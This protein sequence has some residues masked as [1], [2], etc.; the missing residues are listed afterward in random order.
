MT[1]KVNIFQRKQKKTKEN[2]RKFVSLPLNKNRGQVCPFRAFFMPAQII[3]IGVY[4]RVYAVMASQTTSIVYSAG[5]Y[6]LFNFNIMNKNRESQSQTITGQNENGLTAENSTVK[7]K[8]CTMNETT[9]KQAEHGYTVSRETAN[10]LDCILSLPDCPAEIQSILTFL[11]ES[12]LP[13]IIMVNVVNNN[14]YIG[15]ITQSTVNGCN[16]L[17]DYNTL[18][19]AIITG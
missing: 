3:K 9:I 13:V 10:F 7:V 19:K 12:R 4:S 17:G 5:R 16:L 2:K 6:A 14:Q 1:A 8:D 18:V 15:N 11:K